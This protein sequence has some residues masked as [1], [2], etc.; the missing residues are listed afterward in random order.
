MCAIGRC[1]QLR[2]VPFGTIVVSPA[3]PRAIATRDQLGK[4]LVSTAT[5]LPHGTRIATLI[6]VLHC[7]HAKKPSIA[8]GIVA[9]EVVISILQLQKWQAGLGTTPTNR[10]T[11]NWIVLTILAVPSL[12]HQAPPAA[13]W[14]ER[15]LLSP[16]ATHLQMARQVCVP[17]VCALVIWH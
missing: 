15:T 9:M 16:A 14:V 10:R 7:V 5:R 1:D 17:E 12:L 11:K 2:C 8:R 3:T 4:V 6:H 13:A